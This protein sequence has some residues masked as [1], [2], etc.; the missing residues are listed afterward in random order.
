MPTRNGQAAVLTQPV[1]LADHAGSLAYPYSGALRESERVRLLTLNISGPSLVRAARLVGYLAGVDAD[2]YILTETRATPGTAHVL[3]SFSAAGYRVI[4]LSPTS[5]RE[6]GVAVVH[7]LANAEQLLQPR[8]HLSHRVLAV[9]L[10]LDVPIVLVGMYVPSRDSSPE[11]IARK[12]TF[13]AETHRFLESLGAG[14][15]IILMGDLNV[16]HRT[17]VPRYSSF[18][19]WEYDFLENLGE[20]NLV[21]TFCEL[22]PGVQAHSW[23]GRKGAGYRYDYAF[24]SEAL[25]ERVSECDYVPTPRELGV[26]DHAG[27]LMS[28]SARLVRRDVSVDGIRGPAGDAEESG[29][30]STYQSRQQPRR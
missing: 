6:R 11:K 28:L 26:T 2:I 4:T 24:L 10:G 15:N 3:Q 21:D 9:R 16:I 7:R 19:S 8:I 25:Q 17:H 27:L 20:L 14:E 12:K 5:P 23:I 13:L 29:A 18:R 30:I 22:H 1:D